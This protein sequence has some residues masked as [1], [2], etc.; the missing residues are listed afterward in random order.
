MSVAVDVNNVPSNWATY[1]VPSLVVN[2]VTPGTGPVGTQVTIAGA[3]FG[4]SQGTNVLTFN[5]QVASASSWNDS[6]IIATVPDTATTGP[7]VATVTGINSNA[8]AVFTV[9]PPSVQSYSP[10]GGIS[11]TPVTITGSGFQANQRDSTVNFNGIAG[12]IT[13][14]SDTQIVANA[15]TGATSGP[16]LVNV[17][18]INSQSG[19]SF[20]VPNPVITSITPPEAPPSGTVTIIGSG[21]GASDRISPDGVS[22]VLVGSVAINGVPAGVSSWS[23]T[24]IIAVLPGNASSGSITV[25]KYDATSNP[26]PLTVEGTPTVETLSPTSGPVNATVTINGS[27]FGSLQSSNTVQFNGVAAAVTS[28]SDNQISAI[29]PPGTATGPVTVTVAGIN[30]TSQDFTITNSVQVTDSLG[31]T[32][33]Y[34]MAMHG[35]AWHF[36]ASSGGGCSS[37]TIVGN[38]NRDLDSVGQAQSSTDELSHTTSYIYDTAGN[39]TSESTHLDDGTLVQTSYTYNSFGEPLTVT[40]PL[41]NTTTNTYDSNGN[42]LSVTPPRP[43]ALTAPS[44]TQFAYDTKGELTGITDPLNHHTTLDYYPTGLI[45]TITDDQLNVTTY[46]YD[47]RGNRTAVVDAMQNRTTF[48]YDL[49]NRLTKITY[50]DTTFV[51]FGYDTRG[52]RT[53]VTDQNGKTTT[54]AY[55]DADRLTSV[56]TP[57]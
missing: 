18:G 28:W 57:R 39:V 22:T 46:E 15:P 11:G 50:P 19:Y 41:G 30:S 10:M 43:D 20:E 7:A 40:D 48:D 29:V 1:V 8:T 12:T 21:F 2:S 32:S 34:Q 26:L 36:L 49:G 44:V 38:L 25:T 56:T 9:P 35:G 55:D 51:S 52:R 33:F 27:N 47:L 13:S 37:C 3:G 5:G 45:H 31:H 53:S 4:S 54:Y 23:D 6:Q 42:L 24:S 16:L 17:N 14:W